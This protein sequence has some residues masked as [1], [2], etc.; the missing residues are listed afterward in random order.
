MGDTNKLTITDCNGGIGGDTITF[1]KNFKIVNSIELKESHF[2]ILE[3]N[4][5]LYGIKN[6]NIHN[7]D[8]TEVLK[9]KTRCCLF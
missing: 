5:K 7:C 2:N 3:Y 8:S 9:L 1:C 6:V 4:C